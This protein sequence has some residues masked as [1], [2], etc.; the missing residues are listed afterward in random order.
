MA[1]N[2]TA[3]FHERTG[4]LVTLSNDNRTAQRSHPTQEFN[5]GVVL[6]ATAL[7]DDQVF[8]VKIDKKVNSWSG[9]IEIGVTLCDPDSLTFP[10]SA[11]GFRDGTWVMSGSS[12]LKDGHSMIE[13][14]GS[15]LDQLSEGDIVGV[16]RSS[17]GEL[18]FFVNGIDQGPAASGIP[19]DVFAVIDM[20][21][22]CAQVSIVD[23]TDNR[24]NVPNGPV[25]MANHLANEFL[26]QLSTQIVNDLTDNTDLLTMNDD[27]AI[28]NE[29]A[30]NHLT[31]RG[32]EAE[33]LQSSERLCF[34]ERCG[35]LIKLTNGRRTAERRRP[36]DEFNNGVVMTNRPLN[37]D[38]YFEIRLDRLVDKW[39]GS[40]EVGI[41]THNP[42][43]IDLPQTMTNMRSG[44]IMMSGC[45]ILTN[46]KGTRREYGQYNLDTLA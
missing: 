6:S 17:A 4:T 30:N 28:S 16:M 3:R 8:E 43:V 37:D 20:Y 40:I 21:G 14:Y 23:S 24:D 44:T 41:T 9:S 19:S 34:H 36:L 26:A 27:N 10:I 29:L 5:N 18:H 46:G 13:E 45:G 32:N 25:E 11:T 1:S 33:G 42:S 12:V 2:G 38:E 35:S 15:D 22:K 31:D 7:R 39:S